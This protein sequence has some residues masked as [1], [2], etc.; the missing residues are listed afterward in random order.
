[1]Q[2]VLLTLLLS[3]LKL[4]PLP[5]IMILILG[6]TASSSCV[7]SA[8]SRGS[9]QMSQTLNQVCCIICTCTGVNVQTLAA[10]RSTVHWNMLLVVEDVGCHQ[11]ALSTATLCDERPAWFTSTFMHVMPGEPLGGAQ[12]SVMLD[13]DGIQVGIAGIVE[14]EW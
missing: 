14:G 9:W 1:M 12:C 7:P 2:H 5:G 8:I 10:N 6:L 13:W 4:M 3:Q 11:H